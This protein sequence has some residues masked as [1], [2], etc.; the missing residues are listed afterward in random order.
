MDDL[1]DLFVLGLRE[2]LVA[3]G[4]PG[5]ALHP[6][7]ALA[8]LREHHPERSIVELHPCLAHRAK[9]D[10]LFLLV[11]RS[12]CEPAEDGDERR[13]VSPRRPGRRPRRVSL[14]GVEDALDLSMLGDEIFEEPH[15]DGVPLRAREAHGIC[16]AK[17]DRLP[18]MR[19]LLFFA[20]F[21]LVACA[22]KPPPPPPP[23]PPAQA[24]CAEPSKLVALD[25]ADLEKSLA[26]D[27][28]DR[29][30]W[31]RA[32]DGAA[33]EMQGRSYSIEA[34]TN[35]LVAM[36]GTKPQWR[37]PG[38]P[39]TSGQLYV[40]GTQD[41]AVAGRGH[42]HGGL[43][44]FLADTGLSMGKFGA[45]VVVAKGGAYVLDPPTLAHGT[46][47]YVHSD[48]TLVLPGGNPKQVVSWEN[49]LEPDNQAFGAAICSSGAIFAVSH[50][51]ESLTIHRA[52]D[53]A[54]LATYPKPAAGVPA[55]TR[56]GRYVVVRDK[57][58]ATIYQLLR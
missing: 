19:A 14:E 12:V 18:L 38:F 29:F 3:L 7:P 25:T 39:I 53:M 47:T 58:S 55:F 32:K 17:G 40:I 15:V 52:S 23:P 36:V 42:T 21:G 13:E 27:P 9:E 54:V 49:S 6:R 43:D 16:H 50:P 45:K 48:V 20:G 44:L 4:E 10:R 28:E 24:A 31:R 34:G 8:V 11:V 2:R 51:K 30:G 5:E 57:A 46:K 35:D 56:S 26:E 22:A 37:G 33:L 1:E 41:G